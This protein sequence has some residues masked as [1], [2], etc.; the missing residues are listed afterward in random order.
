MGFFQNLFESKQT[1]I[2][3]SQLQ[4][5]FILAIADGDIHS[6]EE[7]LL[8]DYAKEIGLT[9]GEVQE[10]VLSKTYWDF[11]RPDSIVYRYA[12]IFKIYLQ[13]TADGEV[14]PREVAYC[15]IVAKDYGFPMQIVDDMTSLFGDVD[16]MQAG[17]ALKAGNKDKSSEWSKYNASTELLQKMYNVK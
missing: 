11:A 17:L 6:R 2:N 1:K 8:S 5:L 3:K 15:K 12:F 4:T 7:S 13:M 10:R 16:M 14:S 9:F